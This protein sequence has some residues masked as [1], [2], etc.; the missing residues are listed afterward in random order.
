VI[1]DRASRILIGAGEQREGV[2]YYKKSL[3]EQANAVN[4]RCLWHNHL[5]HPSNEV[6]SLLPN[7]LGVSYGL[8]KDQE[9]FCEVI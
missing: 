1:Q 8:H 7:R 5:G 2:Y 9:E 3:S 4:T 6:L